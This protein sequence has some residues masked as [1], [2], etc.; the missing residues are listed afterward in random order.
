MTVPGQPGQRLSGGGMS[1]LGLPAH[2]LVPLFKVCIYWWLFLSIMAF[3]EVLVVAGFINSVLLVLQDECTDWFFFFQFSSH[4]AVV[5]WSRGT[6]GVPPEWHSCSLLPASG[7]W[8]EARWVRPRE[9]LYFY[10]PSFPQYVIFWKI[11]WLLKVN[12]FFI[13]RNLRRI[14]KKKIHDLI[15][16]SK[17]S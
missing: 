15:T 5:A 14:G 17:N 16:M 4:L 7:V 12:C 10:R 2:H 6:F 1:F 8:G 3:S 11:L 13:Q 9:K